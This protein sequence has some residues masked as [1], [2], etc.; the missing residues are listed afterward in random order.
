MDAVFLKHQEAWIWDLEARVLDSE[1]AQ[2]TSK[3]Y[4]QGLKRFALWKDWMGKELFQITKR[5]A[6]RFK[7]WAISQYSSSTIN[8]SVHGIRDFYQ[9]LVD[10]ELISRNLFEGR[11]IKLRRK[12]SDADIIREQ[13]KINLPSMKAVDELMGVSFQ[14]RHMAMIAC[15]AGSG[16]RV[17][18]LVGLEFD[19]IRMN[20]KKVTV[21]DIRPENSKTKAHQTFFIDKKLEK[22]FRQYITE[23]KKSQQKP[24]SLS[25]RGVRKAFEQIGSRCSKNVYPHLL[26]HF[27]A[28]EALRRG[29]R[30]DR[31]SKCLGH[32]SVKTTETYGSVHDVYLDEDFNCRNH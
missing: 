2:N 27:F 26:R 24:F 10:E 22:I 6:K 32:S 30:I 5:D 9:F 11:G 29:L 28:V 1:I 17:G 7:T 31:L 15:I 4:Q 14:D 13:L 23:A 18:T 12:K 25:E 3:T 8:S 21:I 16:I 20:R 19:D